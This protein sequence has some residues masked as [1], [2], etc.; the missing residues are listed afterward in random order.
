M[1]GI[2]GYGASEATR[3]FTDPLLVEMYGDKMFESRSFTLVYAHNNKPKRN[4]IV[5]VGQRQPNDKLIK[6]ESR[7]NV[8]INRFPESDFEFYDE[9][10]YL[11]CV[12]FSFNVSVNFNLIVSV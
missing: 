3:I 7:T 12:R 6:F 4:R 10:K 8:M 9:T 1:G 11:T 2:Y 5:T